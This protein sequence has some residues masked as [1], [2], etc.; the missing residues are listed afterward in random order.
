MELSA[1][2][3]GQTPARWDYTH[4]HPVRNVNLRLGEFPDAETFKARPKGHAAVK[5]VPF[6]YHVLALFSLG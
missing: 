1:A 6:G 2:A 4:L 3:G 5:S